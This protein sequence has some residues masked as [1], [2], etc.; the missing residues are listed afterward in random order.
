MRA[1]GV[2]GPLVVGLAAHRAAAGHLSAA[3][4]L[5]AARSALAC[6]AERP[7]GLSA[8]AS[9]LVLPRG[10]LVDCQLAAARSALA[11]LAERPFG[12]SALAVRLYCHGAAC[13]IVSCLLG[14][15]ILN[16]YCDTLPTTNT[17]SRHTISAAT[18]AKFMCK[19]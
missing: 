18:T 11:C 9:P 3:G 4:W 1:L 12:L 13:W 17:C 8:L 16:N 7:F 15:R 14:D 2:G 19:S 6:L 5:T 10:G